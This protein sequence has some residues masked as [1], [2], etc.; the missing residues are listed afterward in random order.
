[1]IEKVSENQS[2]NQKKFFLPHRSV[3]RQNAVDKIENSIRC[4]DQIR[5]KGAIPSKQIMGHSEKNKV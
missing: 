5:G 1:M 2:E 4:F 3:I